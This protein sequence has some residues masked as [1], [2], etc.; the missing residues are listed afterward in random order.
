MLAL[1]RADAGQSV[2]RERVDLNAIAADVCRQAPYFNAMVAVRLNATGEDVCLMGDPDLLRQLILILLDNALKYTPAGGSVTVGTAS[3][4][5][6]VRLIVKDTGIGMREADIAGAFDRF[7]QADRARRSG[8][9]GLG[10]SIAKWIVE[11]HGASLDIKSAPDQGTTVTVR[12]PRNLPS[13]DEE[14]DSP[15]EAAGEPNGRSV[16][17]AEQPAPPRTD[18]LVSS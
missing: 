3:E 10:L 7:Y 18:D 11:A 1:A 8:G 15:T 12:L 5:R 16:A 2:R 6:G 13:S 9:F 4:L 14:T 17:H